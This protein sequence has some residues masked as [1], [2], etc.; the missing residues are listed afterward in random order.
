MTVTVRL[1]AS[2]AESLGKSELSLDLGAGAT[3]ADVVKAVS[4]MPGANRLPPAPL[5][6]VNCTY[7]Q[8]STNLSDGDEI[9]FIPPVA[10]G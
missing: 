10:G 7:A 9:A 6:A 4:Q 5:V 8:A 2:Y 3:V 1:F